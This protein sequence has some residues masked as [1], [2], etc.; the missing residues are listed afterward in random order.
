MIVLAGTLLAVVACRPAEPDRAVST[1]AIA[2]R[3]N[4]TPS[5]AARGEVV[6]VAWSAATKDTTDVFVAISRDMGRTFGAPVRVND[7]AGQARVSGEFP[8]RVAL[9]TVG[10]G[11]N[12]VVGVTVVWTAPG[13][14][15]GRILSAHSD[16]GGG[17]FLAAAPVPGSEGRGSRGWQSVAVDSSGRVLVLWL[18]HRDVPPMA[19]GHLHGA[20]APPGTKE[21]P[22]ARASFSKVY[23]T[24]LDATTAAPIAG[25]VCYCCKT[26]LVASGEKVYAAWRHVYPGTERDVAVATSTDGGSTFT[27]PVRVS[28]DG[29]S[30]DGCPE[31]GP[32]L[33]LDVRRSLHVAWPAPPDGN[34]DTPLALFYSTSSD[35]ARFAPRTQVPTHGPAGHVQMAM[36]GD[37]LVLVWDEVRGDGRRVVAARAGADASGSRRFTAIPWPGDSVGSRPVIAASGAGAVVA[38]VGPGDGK[39]VVYVAPLRMH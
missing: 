26:S 31:N 11:R 13:P 16:D 10:S 23:F 2:G 14:N 22:T 12:T 20:S 34:S 1:L 8:P 15:G 24:S 4:A 9:A 7:V 17:R 39:S 36:S 18:D 28:R 21:D 25:G 19:P 33:A 35:G 29:W 38:W 32:A 5:I 3:A 6:A 30:I 27:G 37:D